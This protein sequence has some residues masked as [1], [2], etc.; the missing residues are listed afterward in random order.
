MAEDD[1]IQQVEAEKRA[2]TKQK[3]GDLAAFHDTEAAEAQGQEATAKSE[4]NRKERIAAKEAR[5]A[6]IKALQESEVAKCDG[7]AAQVQHLKTEAD[8]AELE[9]RVPP[10]TSSGPSK[11]SDVATPATNAVRAMRNAVTRASCAPVET[12][13]HAN[14]RRSSTSSTLAPL[15]QSPRSM[16]S[17]VLP[18]ANNVSSAVETAD[19]RNAKFPIKGTRP[20]NGN[21]ASTSSAHSRRN[22]TNAATK[23]ELSPPV[24]P[25]SANASNLRLW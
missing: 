14:S 24:N 13:N 22:S 21:P 4:R 23:S 25:M 8:R 7:M 9:L 16:S 17:P 6:K 1:P 3:E 19:L 18:A 12:K 20:K 15:A 10:R 5:K 2:S 11:N